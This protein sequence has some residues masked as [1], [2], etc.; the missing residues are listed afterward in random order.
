[1]KYCI[2]SKDLDCLVHC[3]MIGIVSFALGKERDIMISVFKNSKNLCKGMEIETKIPVR[4][5][6]YNS[7]RSP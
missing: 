7:L 6:F 2:F 3:F 5:C 4:V 1:M